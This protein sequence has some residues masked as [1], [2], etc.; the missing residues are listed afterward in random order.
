MRKVLT[1]D[2]LSVQQRLG[3]VG[4]TTGSPSGGVEGGRDLHK[5]GRRSNKCKF[6]AASERGSHGEHHQSE[7]SE[8]Q[9][10]VW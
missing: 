2:A 9:M 3:R 4:R 1:S 5:T 6:A 10:A 7:V 8:L